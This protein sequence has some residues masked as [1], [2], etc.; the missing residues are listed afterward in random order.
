MLLCCLLFLAR[1]PPVGQGLLIHE[2]SRSHTQ[3]RTT[4]GR[5]PLDKWSGRRRDLYLTTQMLLFYQILI[6]LHVSVVHIGHHQVGHWFTKILKRGEASAYKQ[7]DDW[8]G[9]P[10][11]VVVSNKSQIQKTYMVVLTGWL[12]KTRM[13][14]NSCR[15]SI[16]VLNKI[17]SLIKIK[18]IFQPSLTYRYSI[19]E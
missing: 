10:K 8:C 7:H 16:W 13:L 6:L 17:F 12:N 14:I 1:Q 2:V 4:V 15:L 9:Q 19:L 18:R 11:H 5:T 3:R